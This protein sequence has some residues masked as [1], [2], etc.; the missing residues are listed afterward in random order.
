VRYAR[1]IGLLTSLALALVFPLWA[2]S[3]TTS[4]AIF[5]LI[6]AGMATGWNIFSGYTGY[7]S[8]GHMVYYGLGAYS[9]ATLC[10]DLHVPGGSTPMLL[11]PLAGL[12]AGGCAIPLGWIALRTRRH[13]FMVIT[14]AIFFLFQ[15]LAYNLPV[16]NG[17]AGL[18]LP[19]PPWSAE[20]FDVPFYYVALLYLLSALAVSRWLWFS[21]CGLL[22]LAIRDDEDRARSL[23]VKSGPL[24]LSTY[25][26]SAFFLGLAGA[27]SAYFIGLISPLTVFDPS[28]NVVIIVMVFLGGVGTL[29]GPLL[30]AALLEPLQ[31]FLTVQFGATPGLNLIVY[32]LLLLVIILALPEGVV[33]ALRGKR[34]GQIA[35]LK[36]AL[37]LPK[38]I[39]PALRGKWLRWIAALKTASSPPVTRT[40]DQEQPDR[41]AQEGI[42]YALTSPVDGGTHAITLRFDPARSALFTLS[43]DA[44]QGELTVTVR[45]HTLEEVQDPSQSPHHLPNR[46]PHQ[47]P[48]LGTLPRSPFPASTAYA[49]ESMGVQQQSDVTERLARIFAVVLEVPVGEVKS[50]T[51]FFESG[52]DVLALAALLQ[53]VERQFTLT[54]HPEDVFAHAELSQLAELLLTRQQGISAGP[55][56]G[57]RD[58]LTTYE[59]EEYAETGIV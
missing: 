51:N 16:S 10:Q 47:I 52:G 37:A 45:A 21:K 57:K 50:T 33:P 17:S 54:L 25:V 7:I 56:G 36:P 1:P 9:L 40:I 23:G 48:G 55:R 59:L 13:T 19:N 3:A 30:G 42:L 35:A 43:I 27:L 15:V 6:F 29:T 11:L 41:V 26:L 22:L 49:S 34:L 2:D 18:F 53:A 12:V 8:L 38:V 4:I 39:V 20:V 24:K 14:I 58:S 5:T 31:Q 28:Y 32:G 46:G 44:V